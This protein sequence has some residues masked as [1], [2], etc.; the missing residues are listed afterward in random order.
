MTDTHRQRL[1]TLIEDYRLRTSQPQLGVRQLSEQ[2]R[3]ADVYVSRST[4][5]NLLNSTTSPDRSTLM[6]LARFFG[7]DVHYFDDQP[8]TAA[9]MGRIGEL[10]E[11][12]LEAVERLLADLDRA[13]GTGP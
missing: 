12:G 5:Y 13:D 9:I 6:S 1:E 11:T 7:V 3:Q 8:R 2:M 10:N 4:L